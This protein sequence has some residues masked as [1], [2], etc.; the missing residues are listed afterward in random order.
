[1]TV[2]TRKPKI[3]QI[4]KNTREIYRR[5]WYHRV[6]S[7][8]SDDKPYQVITDWSI[9]ADKVITIRCKLFSFEAKYFQFRHPA[10]ISQSVCSH[11]LAS[12]KLAA[13]QAGKVLS[14]PKDGEYKSAKRLLNLGGNLVRVTNG[15]GVIWGVV[16]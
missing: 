9:S 7:V 3:N 14:L 5:N 12:V 16:R 1:M 8:K 10:N 11:F 6:Y 2:Q 15:N 13:R 4:L